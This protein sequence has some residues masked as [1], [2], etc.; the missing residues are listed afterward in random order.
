M[1]EAR[2]NVMLWAVAA[3]SKM[4]SMR[5]IIHGLLLALA[6]C[7]VAWAQAPAEHLLGAGDGIR[8]TVYQN[9]DLTLE[10]RLSEQGQISFPLIGAVQLGGLTL[11][12][13]QDRIAKMLRDGGFVLKPQVSV[14]LVQVRSSQVSILGQVNRPGRYPIETANSKVSEMIAAAGGV[15]PGGGDVVSLSGTRNG[16]PVKYDIDLPAVMQAGRTDLD[17]TV[18]NGDIIYVDRAPVV[19]LYGEVQRPG[20]IRLERG[21]TLMQ[22][23]AQAGGLTQRGTER[24]MRVHRRDASGNLNVLQLKLSDPIEREDVIYVRESVF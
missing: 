17:V 1:S 19:Y 15:L 11:T 8:V 10:T 21:M 24:G 23:L 2:L 5:K 6:L 16:K 3:M 12:G 13:A 18:A 4:S 22:A 9:P 20:A 14:Q 7:P